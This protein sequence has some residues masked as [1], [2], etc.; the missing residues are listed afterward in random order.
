MSLLTLAACYANVISN[1]TYAV[2]FSKPYCFTC[3]DGGDTTSKVFGSKH[4]LL[5]WLEHSSNDNIKVFKLIPLE[6]QKKNFGKTHMITES[7]Q[8]EVPLFEWVIGDDE[9]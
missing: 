2:T 5:H 7:V 8:K 9:L 3:M 6:A 1:P 4:D